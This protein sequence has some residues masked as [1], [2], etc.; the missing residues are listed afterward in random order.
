MKL[1]IGYS[2][3]KKIIDQKLDFVDKSLFIKEFLDNKGTEVS[4]ITRPRRFGKTLNLSMLHCFLAAEVNGESTK[5]LFDNLKIASAENYSNGDSYISQQGQHPVIFVT[6]KNVKATSFSDAVEKLCSIIQ[7]LYREHQYLLNSTTLPETEKT[8]IQKYLTLPI[9][10]TDIENSILFLSELL[11][12]HHQQKK[13]YILIDE[14][15]TPIQASYLNNY[16]NDMIK[17]M[18]GILGAAL[19]GNPCLNRAVITGIIRIAK[20]GLFSDLNNVEIYSILE[21]KYSQYFGFTEEE[22]L[23]LLNRAQMSDKIDEIKEWYNG[24]KFAETTVYNPWSIVHYIQK[25]KLRDYWANT[26]G[27]DLIWNLIVESNAEIKNDLEKLL[28]GEICFHPINEHVVFGDLKNNPA[29][30]WS[31][32]ANTGYLNIISSEGEGSILLCKTKIPNKEVRTIYKDMIE[33]WLSSSSGVVWYN[34][35]L[36]HLLNGN[37]SEVSIDLEKLFLHV[38]SFRDMGKKPEAFYHGLLLGLTGSLS[39]NLYEINSNGEG[40]DGYYDIIIIP[41]DLSKL[42]VVLELKSIQNLSKIK[43]ESTIINLL[44]NSANQAL[45]QIDEKDYVAAAR[46]AGIKQVFRIGIAFAGKRFKIKSSVGSSDRIIPAIHTI[47]TK[48]V[49]VKSKTKAKTKVPQNKKTSAL[50][51][52]KTAKTSMKKSKG[53]VG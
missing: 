51:T 26:S 39:R 8:I 34:N 9:N 6:F 19:K 21:S 14:Y 24:Y 42:A 3:F 31:I 12:K 29:A 33:T 2:D 25:G 1:A 48:K 37:I 17:L 27:N 5:G 45:N 44:E 47:P 49:S 28:R 15:D 43:K 23:S 20:E 32:L 10:K 11:Y 46:I 38:I 53:F 7:T 36:N 4:V 40:G 41:K 13:V 50:K 18:G 35:F 16:Y 52:K 22:V 30:M